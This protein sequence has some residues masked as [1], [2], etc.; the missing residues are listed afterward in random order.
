MNH[1]LHSL[2]SV[3]MDRIEGLEEFM[4]TI[5]KVREINARKRDYAYLL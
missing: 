5:F 2:G 3:L 1:T 4:Q